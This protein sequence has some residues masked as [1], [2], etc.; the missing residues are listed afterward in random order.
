MITHYPPPA[1]PHDI[2]SID[3]PPEGFAGIAPADK[4]FIDECRQSLPPGRHGIPVVA[5]M[6]K[7]MKNR[8]P[9]PPLG[10]CGRVGKI[11][12]TVGSRL[13]GRFRADHIRV[14]DPRRFQHRLIRKIP[15]HTVCVFLNPARN[16][17]PLDPNGM[18]AIQA[19]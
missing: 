8:R 1:R 11:I 14:H 17:S 18:A 2:R 12:E 9:K 7:N 13:T 19:V 10:F 15:A 3:T 16:R 5:S 6:R 4:G